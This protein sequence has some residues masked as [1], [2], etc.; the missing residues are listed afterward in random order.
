MPR[1]VTNICQNLSLTNLPWTSLC[2]LAFLIIVAGL[3]CTFVADPCLANFAKPFVDKAEAAEGQLL[4]I[5]KAVVG[6]GA[7]IAIMLFVTGR[8]QWKLAIIVTG[9]G[10]ALS[11]WPLLKSFIGGS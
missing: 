10:V 9:V 6:V 3:L 8:P 11:A 1:F 5:G 7:L 2:S 4:L